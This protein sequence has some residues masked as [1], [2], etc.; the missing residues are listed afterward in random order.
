MH[1]GALRRRFVVMK[2]AMRSGYAPT[3]QQEVVM[4]DSQVAAALSS[5][6][7]ER[8]GAQRFELWFSS[9]AQ[10]CVR[11]G[12][13]DHSRG[14][15]VCARLAAEEFRRRHSGVLGGDRRQCRDRGV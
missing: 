3:E 12:C 6:L 14:Q 10:L 11:A 9:Q 7:A 4:E 2:A 13:T 15:R 5:Q 1:G 8:I